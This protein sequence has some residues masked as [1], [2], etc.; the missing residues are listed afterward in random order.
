M[1]ALLGKEESNK[2]FFICLFVGLLFSLSIALLWEMFEYAAYAFFGI[3]MQEDMLID[4]FSSY[5]LMGTHNATEVIDGI[6]QTVIYYADGTKVILGGYL[7]VG[8]FDTLNDML[9]CLMGGVVYIAALLIDHKLGG[10]L[11]RLLVPETNAFERAK[12][13]KKEKAPAKEL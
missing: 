12:R 11:R 9:V 6:T 8:L 13:Q 2:N 5:F 3:D 1:K 10:R 7:D 4:G